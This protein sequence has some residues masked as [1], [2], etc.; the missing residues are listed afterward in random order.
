MKKHNEPRL[1]KLPKLVKD[2]IKHLEQ[3]RSDFVANVSHELRTPLTVIQGYL[4]TL[5][6]NKYPDKK[7]LNKIF[8]QMYQHSVRMGDIIEDLL[9]LAHL[10]GED[11]P[12]DE[13]NGIIIADI[14]KT[15][16]MDAKN[17]SGEKKHKITL[18]ADAHVLM[19]GS[20]SELRSLFSNIIVNA[21]KYTPHAGRIAIEWG[22]D[23]QGCG[24]FRV[25]DTG[26]GI[27]KE[28]LPRLTERFYRVDK[29]RSRERGGTGLGL[30]IVKHVI[31]R[32]GGQLEI[33]SIPDKGSTFT[34]IFPAE[35]IT[36]SPTF[37]L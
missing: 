12:S 13:K 20:E 3:V 4:E 29:A 2:Y 24:I 11:H 8:V 27:A 25:S 23:K 1:Q 36:I 34:C 6:K 5:I 35:R 16:K 18:K 15:I 30:A 9:L 14:L 7:T 33:E 21:I 19:N 31:I 10:E 28:H 26:I 22:R 17:L 32:H 37:S